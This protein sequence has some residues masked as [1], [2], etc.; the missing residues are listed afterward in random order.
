M[1]SLLPGDTV[2][3]EKKK[4]NP[5]SRHT[6][7]LK[8]QIHLCVSTLWN[9]HRNNSHY[10]ESSAWLW[11]LLASGGQTGGNNECCQAGSPFWQCRSAQGMNGMM[12]RNDI[13]VPLISC[14][15]ETSAVF[16]LERLFVFLLSGNPSRS[17]K[18]K[19]SFLLLAQLTSQHQHFPLCISRKLHFW[20]KMHLFISKCGYSGHN[21]FIFKRHK[22]ILHWEAAC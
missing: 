19:H 9:D 2:E 4:K 18:R 3:G 13:T 1:S 5:R 21:S 11:A 14:Q 20:D 15:F 22:G 12:A 17:P 6:A 10:F 7:P 8:V 16:I